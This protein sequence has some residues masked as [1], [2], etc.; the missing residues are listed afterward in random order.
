MVTRPEACSLCGGPVEPWPDGSNPP[1][2]YGHN[3]EPL[4]PFEE[5]CC[6]RCNDTKVIPARI[7]RMYGAIE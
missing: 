5:R 3:P 6:T 7:R 1:H 4:A 2:G